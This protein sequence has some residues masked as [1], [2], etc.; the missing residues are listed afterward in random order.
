[1]DIEFCFIDISKLK[2]LD[3]QNFKDYIIFTKSQN[4]EYFKKCL[5]DVIL[6]TFYMYQDTI[7]MNKMTEKHF[8]FHV[9]QE[10]SSSDLI[11][12]TIVENWNYAL[13]IGVLESS[14][15]ANIYLKTYF[16]NLINLLKFL[17]GSLTN[18]FVKH[19]QETSIII[20]KIIDNFS[21][22]SLQKPFEYLKTYPNLL[23]DFLMDFVSMFNRHEKEY[24]LI[25]DIYLMRENSIIYA[26]NTDHLMELFLYH[27]VIRTENDGIHPKYYFHKVHSSDITIEQRYS[28][29]I[30]NAVI[31]V[32]VLLNCQLKDLKSPPV[33]L[34]RRSRAFIRKLTKYVKENVPE[35]KLQNHRDIDE[36][37]LPAGGRKDNKLINWFRS[38]SLSLSVVDKQPIDSETSHKTM[39]IFGDSGG[40]S[41]MPPIYGLKYRNNSMNLRFDFPLRVASAGGGGGGQAGKWDEL[42]VLFTHADEQMPLLAADWSMKSFEVAYFVGL[43]D[44]ESGARRSFAKIVGIYD[45]SKKDWLLICVR[46]DCAVDLAVCLNNVRQ[47]VP[48]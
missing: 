4:K 17:F 11:V 23:E 1:M 47:F 44:E 9:N 35:V 8:E 18:S 21:I 38:R 45:D 10:N 30:S 26:R 6:T 27:S 28:L 14:L 37:V 40:F 22:L 33:S 31:T 12:L 29:L 3:S 48:G 34:V 20:D 19:K 42:A 32:I 39:R 7:K 5:A 25:S 2:V 41:S 43:G 36:L 16:E 15:I 24:I 46:D 13:L